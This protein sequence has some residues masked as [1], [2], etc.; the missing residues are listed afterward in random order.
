MP[1]RRKGPRLY[2]RPR[3]GRPST[4]V[5][6]DR[7]HEVGTGCGEG[8]LER[9]EQAL[10]R[11]IAS[12]YSPPQK[13]GNQ[14]QDILIADVMTAYLREHA[15]HTQSAEFI[16]HTASP[17]IDWWGAKTLAD[18]RGSTCREYVAWRLKS[19]VSAQTARHD[20]KTLR[21][22]INHYHREY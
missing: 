5:I 9:A 1:R 21:A 4:W 16:K 12:K 8:E 19:K 18:I 10:E 11:Y 13:I 3:A 14:L 7:V 2:L 6:R 17:I 20:L 22:A 15:P